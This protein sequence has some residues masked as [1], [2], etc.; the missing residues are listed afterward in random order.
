MEFDTKEGKNVGTYRKWFNGVVKLTSIS[1]TSSL[2]SISVM[3]DVR[4]EGPVAKRR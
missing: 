3:Y 2:D 4:D 1:L